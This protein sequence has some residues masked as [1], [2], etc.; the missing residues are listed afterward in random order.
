MT[1]EQAGETLAV[2]VF[3]SL[4]GAGFI[5]FPLSSAG[6]P[7]RF[8]EIAPQSGKTT[9]PSYP[10][11]SARLNEKQYKTALIPVLENPSLKA[12]VPVNAVLVAGGDSAVGPY[13]ERVKQ[14]IVAS[15]TAAGY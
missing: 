6:A 13:I 11:L 8:A 10:F 9:F 14:A 5:R 7:S 3:Y 4:I 2:P 1:A 12:D 15:F